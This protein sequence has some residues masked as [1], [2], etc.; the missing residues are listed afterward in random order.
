MDWT[1]WARLPRLLPLLLG[2]LLA[3]NA[4]ARMNVLVIMTDDQRFDSVSRMPTLSSLARKGVQFTKAYQPTPVCGPARASMYSGGFLSQNTGVLENSAPNGGINLF[5]DRVNLGTVMQ[6]AGYR[7][8]FAGKWVNGYESRGDYVPPGWSKFVGRRSFANKTSWYSFRYTVG[9]SGPSASGYGTTVASNAYTA[10]YER[11]QILRFL[12]GVPAT[13]PFFIFW[14][15]SAPHEIAMPAPQDTTAFSTFLYRGRGVG[16]TDLSDKPRWVRLN[17]DAPDDDEFMRDQLRTLLSVDRSLGAILD[18]LRA[19]GELDETVIIYTSD[20]GYQWNEHGLW[21]KD[22]PYEESARVPFIVSMPGVA[23]RTERK[24]VAPVLDVG[25]TIYELAGTSRKSD[26]RSLVPLLRNPGATW[27][28]DLFFEHNFSSANGNAL[29][30]G[31]VNHR[32]KYI[33][34]WTGEEE[35]YDLES[36]PFE[37]RSRHADL[38]LQ[39][40]KGTLAARTDAQLGLAIVPEPRMPAASIFRSYSHRLR[41]WGGTSP[42]TWVIASGAL[43][44]GLSLDRSTGTIR[45]TPLARGSY[46]F[47][48]RVTDSGWAT[49]ASRPRT[50][51]TKPITL[52]VS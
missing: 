26:G 39:S 17:K 16:E 5:V 42:F 8:L 50:F 37:L 12:D 35:L 23:A 33:R 24:L 46:L 20:N 15:P 47:Q 13:Q 49:Q 48:V 43:P 44:P 27:R 22:K 30:A 19:R 6:Q 11:D 21:R 40:L 36:D 34:Y 38:S 29:W 14:S 2:A 52:T 18:K 10:Y 41:P 25:P 9:S 45:G 1:T 31:V 51:L 28:R 7:T 3:G 4:H 32:W